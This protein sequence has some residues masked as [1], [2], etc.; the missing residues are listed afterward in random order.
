MPTKDTG[1]AKAVTQ[2]DSR[3]ESSTSAMP[4]TRCTVTPTLLA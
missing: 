3:L 4:G 2:A 1:P